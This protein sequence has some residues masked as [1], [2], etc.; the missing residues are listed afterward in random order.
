MRL[1]TASVVLLLAT[2]AMASNY[3]TCVLDKA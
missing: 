3:A 1:L 2:P